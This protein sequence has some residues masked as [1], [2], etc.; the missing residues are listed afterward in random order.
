MQKFLTDTL[1]G[2][3]IKSLLYNSYIPSYRTIRENDFIISGVRYAYK[4]F[5]IEAT[6]TGYIDPTDD[7]IQN[8]ASYKIID[9]YT[10]GD[11]NVKFTH[12][13]ISKTN[14]YDSETHIHLGN[15]LRAYRDL[16]NVDLL[17]F[18]NCYCD[19]YTSNFVVSESGIQ[20]SYK[21][22]IKYETVEIPIRYN[23]TYTIALDSP[24]EV[25]IC[26]A[27]FSHEDLV[28]VDSLNI[29]KFLWSAGNIVK[30]PSMQFN[31]PVTY[32]L[33]NED[34][35][36]QTYEKNLY[37]FIQIPYGLKSSIVVLEGDYTDLSRKI[38]GIESVQQMDNA[39]LDYY[40]LSNLSLLKMNDRMRY[41]FS[42][43]LVEYLYNNPVDI[44]EE[45]NGNIQR[46]QQALSSDRYFRTKK[47]IWQDEL[48]NLIYNRYLDNST[49]PYD[50]NGYVDKDVEKYLNKELNKKSN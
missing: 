29:S 48:R 14:Y 3:Y 49:S 4:E 30:Y 37:L 11:R 5:I 47:D 25:I 18:Y 36:L 27:L 40:M 12:N 22:N 7:K 39:Q 13:Y 34:S 21:K 2:R 6:S 46:V 23:Q 20:A 42:D 24:S 28:V 10:F 41:A 50:I 35:F 8:I 44:N 15:Y 1:T 9:L 43:R 33:H 45:V 26:P 16:M 31:Y 19:K 38:I 17:P 32:M